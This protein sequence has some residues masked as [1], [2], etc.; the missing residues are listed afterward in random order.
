MKFRVGILIRICTLLLTAVGQEFAVLLNL[1]KLTAT[2]LFEIEFGILLQLLV[3][4]L[5]KT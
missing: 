3:K 1:E 5:I 2:D 4:L